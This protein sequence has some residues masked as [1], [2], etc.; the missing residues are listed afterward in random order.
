MAW[1][2][3]LFGAFVGGATQTMMG[4]GASVVMMLIYPYFFGLTVAPSINTSVCLFLSGSV[5]WQK[6][7]KIHWKTVLPAAAIFSVLSVFSIQMLGR[8]NLRVLALAFG[9]FLVFISLFYLLLDKRAQ[10]RG[11]PLTMV[12]CSA[13]SGVFGGLFGVGGPLMAVYFLS[14]SN[15]TEEYTANIQGLFFFTNLVSLTTRIL[16]GLY[17]VPLLP[18]T[19]VGVLGVMGG[20]FLGLRLQGRMS[21]DK[22]RKAVYAFVGLCGVLNIVTELI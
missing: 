3:V 5:A 19:I 16:K 17:T 2:A 21:L 12:V 6:R 20:K 14:V 1:L 11:T 7:D 9:A 13:V 4:F 8:L 10:L 15:D 22:L 18:Y